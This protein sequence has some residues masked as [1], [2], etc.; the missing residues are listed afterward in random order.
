M[1]QDNK[2]PV[3]LIHGM[4]S[5]GETLHEVRDAFIWQGY[6]VDSVTLPYHRPRAEHTSASLASLARATLQDYVEFLVEHVKKMPSAPIIVGHSMG[7]LLA[8]LTAARVPCE[9]LVLLS[10]AAPAGINGL[11]FSVFRTLGSNLFRFPLWRSATHL[12]LA[13][14]TYGVANTQSEAVQ[15][16]VFES[17]SYESGMVTFQMTL[18]AFSR[19]TFANVEPES[20]RCPVLII[21][22]V[23][24]RI[25]PIGVQR[26]IAKRYGE[27]CQLVEIPGCDHWTV[28]GRFFPE[29]RH[30]LFDWL[31]GGE[32]TVKT[33]EALAAG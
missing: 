28:G 13:N 5:D 32:V 17:C 25:T 7:G 8:Q 20:I 10:S 12:K 26:R 30:A 27:R 9:R 29:I 1:K 24:D 21:G 2:P 14:V 6:A 18:A 22:G 19:K 23:E 16:E 3:L 15:R 31:K 33:E 4:W 11:G